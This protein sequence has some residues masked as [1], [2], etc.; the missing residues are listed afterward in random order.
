MLETLRFQMRL[1]K[2][3]RCLKVQSYGFAARAV[4]EIGKLVGALHT[5][6]VLDP[7]SGRECKL[8]FDGQVMRNSTS[9]NVFV[10]TPER[11]PYATPCNPRWPGFF[12]FDTP[13]RTNS[14]VGKIRAGTQT[15]WK[16][17]IKN[18]HTGK[19]R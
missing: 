12:L 3:L 8:P 7:V 6:P 4:D 14:S 15:L 5:D 16:V 1:A 19:F 11:H 17:Q 2:D 9:N 18:A 10:K 13:C